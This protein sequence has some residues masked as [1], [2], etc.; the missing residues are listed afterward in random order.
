M[1]LPKQE[2][3]ALMC[4]FVLKITLT[5]SSLTGNAFQ[6]STPNIYTNSFA[7][8]Q[9]AKNKEHRYCVISF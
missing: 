3:S 9:V 4:L 2:K 8:A 7:S 1:T 6:Q 5:V